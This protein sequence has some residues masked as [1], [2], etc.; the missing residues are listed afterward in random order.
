MNHNLFN[1]TFL[2]L[3]N[4]KI[5]SDFIIKNFNKKF[6][7]NNFDIIFNL[8][9]IEFFQDKYNYTNIINIIDNSLFYSRIYYNNLY[10]YSNLQILNIHNDRYIN[11]TDIIHLNNLK[12]LILPKNKLITDIGLQF[13]NKLEIL[14]LEINKNITNKSLI[15]KI[16]L[17]KLILKHNK[18][19]DDSGFINMKKLKYLNLGYNNNKKL[20]LN[21]IKNNHLDTLILYKKKNIEQDIKFLIK[22]INNIK[23]YNLTIK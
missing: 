3:S 23:L 6:N 11:D 5:H 10:N 15:N 18:K 4:H 21:F 8:K 20:K 9:N 22:S 19:I 14:N 17:R 12:E 16:E 2:L 7:L 1:Y 13:L